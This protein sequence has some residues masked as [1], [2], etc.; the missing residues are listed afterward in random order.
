[1]FADLGWS[2]AQKHEQHKRRMKPKSP[3]REASI[4]SLAVT[5]DALR[6]EVQ[7]MHNDVQEFVN[8]LIIPIEKELR[9]HSAA[10]TWTSHPKI[11]K[12]KVYI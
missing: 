2:L 5:V 7:I 6:P 11:E 4:G 10:E 8:E 9:D 12:L 3:K 1:M